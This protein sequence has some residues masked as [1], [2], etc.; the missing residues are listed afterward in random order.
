MPDPHTVTDLQSL[1]ALF[2]SVGEASVRKEVP[3]LHPVYRQWIEASPF[4]VL[5]TA[6]AGGLDA[7]P[8][9]DPRAW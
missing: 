6:G 2:G 1:E 8:R 3:F 4:A 9:G 7:S 5:A